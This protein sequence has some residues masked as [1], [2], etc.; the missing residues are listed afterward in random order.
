MFQ[1]ITRNPKPFRLSVLQ[2]HQLRCYSG[3]VTTLRTKFTA[4]LFFSSYRCS[5]KGARE[6]LYAS[7][8]PSSATQSLLRRYK[9]KLGQRCEDLPPG[10]RWLSP[11]SPTTDSGRPLPPR[12][13]TAQERSEA[14]NHTSSPQ[15]HREVVRTTSRTL[16]RATRQRLP[17]NH[18]GNWE[19]TSKKTK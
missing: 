3:L 17:G 15:L 9:S 11:R 1:A 18:A 14:E 6:K 10:S 7:R 13:D 16:S 8:S 5:I 2:K 19:T 4:S 12:H